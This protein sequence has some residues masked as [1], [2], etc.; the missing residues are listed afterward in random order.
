[1][2]HGE[3]NSV[4]TQYAGNSV[5]V[6]TSEA[7]PTL[8]GVVQ[9]EAH[10]DAQKLTLSANTEP[11]TILNQLIAAEIQVEWF[12]I[13]IPTLDEIFIQVVQAPEASE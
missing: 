10:N 9:V 6:R 8:E 4:R 13:A 11:K 1:L 7:L 5:F 2:L 3:I 12:E